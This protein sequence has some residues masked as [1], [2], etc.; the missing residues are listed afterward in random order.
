MLLHL[1]FGQ[2]IY[3]PNQGTMHKEFF[4]DISTYVRDN[5]ILLGDFNLV[6]NV[7][8]RKSGQL[9]STSSLLVSLLST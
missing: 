5:M 4:D 6:T 1:S 8:D 3:V 9:D 7:A 2:H